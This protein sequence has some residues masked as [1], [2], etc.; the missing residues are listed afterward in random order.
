MSLSKVCNSAVRFMKFFRCPNSAGQN[1][2][3][4]I[5]MSE[6]QYGDAEYLFSDMLQRIGKTQWRTAPQYVIYECNLAL[7]YVRQHRVDEAKD[8]L[9]KAFVRLKDVSKEF[10]VYSIFPLQHSMMIDIEEGNLE[11]AKE[12]LDMLREH[13]LSPQLPRG[14]SREWFTQLQSSTSLAS[15]ILF[16]QT[17]ELELAEDSYQ[18]FLRFRANDQA[19]ITPLSVKWMNLLA[20]EYLQNKMYE[21]A[22]DLLNLSYGLLRRVP[23]HPDC[24]QT[25]GLFRQLLIDTNRKEDIEDMLAWVRPLNRELI[26]QDPV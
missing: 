23:N 9:E 3:A 1:V 4:G 25:L 6:G 24:Q 10:E 14:F 11:G 7:A 2:L 15:A 16:I 8:I 13:F 20:K 17:G 19:A 21:R 12:K 5:K 22:E 26:G 18:S